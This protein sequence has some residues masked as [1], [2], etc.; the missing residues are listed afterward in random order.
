M[1]RCNSHPFSSCSHLKISTLPWS[2]AQFNRSPPY[3]APF[4]LT[5]GHLKPVRIS[6][7]SQTQRYQPKLCDGMFPLF[8]RSK[9]LCGL[10]FVSNFHPRSF[11]VSRKNLQVIARASRSFSSTIF[12]Q[13]SAGRRLK[14]LKR[15][16][17]LASS[18]AHKAINSSFARALSL[19]F[20][21][22]SSNKRTTSLFLH[23]RNKAL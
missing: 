14:W 4:T 6:K 21:L 18:L 7:V 19:P 12:C 8:R 23:R 22:A 9:R 1:S 13:S 16:S 5:S 3:T 20:A 17:F 2:A 10:K 11:V 15:F